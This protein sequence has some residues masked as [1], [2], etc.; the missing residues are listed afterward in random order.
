MKFNILEHTSKTK[1]VADNRYG[2]C[3]FQF[4][5]VSA[6]K[7]CT[8]QDIETSGTSSTVNAGCEL[9]MK[10]YKKPNL[11]YLGAISPKIARLEAHIRRERPNFF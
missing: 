10:C 11:A 5:F 2:L 4:I 7:H 1:V 8:A 6:L 9:D 3:L